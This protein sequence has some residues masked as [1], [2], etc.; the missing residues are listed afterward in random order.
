MKRKFDLPS[1]V[2]KN[3]LREE[4]KELVEKG[5]KFINGGKE[6][7][8]REKLQDLKERKIH[9]RREREIKE[10][11][12]NPLS[13]VELDIDINSSSTENPCENMLEEKFVS[14]AELDININLSSIEKPSEGLFEKEEEESRKNE[15][16]LT[17]PPTSIVE[18]ESLKGDCNTL[19]S[20]FPLNHNAYSYSQKSQKQHFVMLFLILG[21]EQHKGSKN[22]FEKGPISF[23]QNFY[24]NTKGPYFLTILF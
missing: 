4:M 7:V 3:K 13:G 23:Q 2:K 11:K 8:R 24:K 10:L 9:E 14:G 19:N 21:N 15:E 18:K 17:T 12:E 16:Y 20:P 5:R 1:Y 6:Y 22:I